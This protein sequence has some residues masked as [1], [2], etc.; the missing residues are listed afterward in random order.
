MALFNLGNYEDVRSAKTDRD[1][2]LGTVLRAF[3]RLTVTACNGA[4]SV[5]GI[6]L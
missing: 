3:R 1:A 6:T 5:D 2:L 4:L